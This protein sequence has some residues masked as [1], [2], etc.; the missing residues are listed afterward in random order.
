MNEGKKGKKKVWKA[1]EPQTYPVFFFFFFFFFCFLFFKKSRMVR[2][3]TPVSGT[4]GLEFVSGAISHSLPMHPVTGMT[5]Q[6][7][8][9]PVAAAVSGGVAL[10]LAALISALNHREHGSLP[11]INQFGVYAPERFIFQIGIAVATFF[12]AA[13]T[14]A[15]FLHRR[16][17][18]ST[19]N[20][21]VLR[22]VRLSTL[23]HVSFAAGLTA[24]VTLF[25]LSVVSVKEEFLLHQTLVGLFF[26]AALAQQCLSATIV[27]VLN[28]E[29][30]EAMQIDAR[31]STAKVV[32]AIACLGTYFFV[33][34]FYFITPHVSASAQP[35][36]SSVGAVNTYILV[37]CMLAFHVSY[38]Y[39]L[40]GFRIRMVSDSAPEG[41]T[42]SLDLSPGLMPSRRRFSSASEAAANRGGGGDDTGGGG[43]ENRGQGGR[44]ARRRLHEADVFL[45]DHDDPDF[46]EDA[47]LE[48]ILGPAA[49]AGRRQ[50]PSLGAVGGGNN[51]AGRGIMGADLE[52]DDGGLFD[53]DEEEDED[54]E[55]DEE[56]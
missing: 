37:A 6:G 8:F 54:E 40:R 14:L 46:D 10:A 16:I 51:G 55:D 43:A 22:L 17:V 39:D 32:L 3:Y 5:V 7:S 28:R 52:L 36:L 56:Q 4:G 47:V 30:I 12:Y 13:T 21:V 38:K 26:P 49:G 2:K 24:C 41:Q 1:S 34:L 25:L 50:E 33:P 9:F 45:L 20:Y 27:Y 23:N 15:L 53:D 42:L 48:G 18:V 35:E 19:Q 11:S 31:W 29:Q 44:S